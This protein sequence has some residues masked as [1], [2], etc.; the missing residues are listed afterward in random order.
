[1]RQD[2]TMT[3]SARAAIPCA[4]AAA[5]AAML[6]AM[7]TAELCGRQA[8]ALDSPVDHASAVL[9]GR[10]VRIE[11]GVRAMAGRSTALSLAITCSGEGC[12]PPRGPPPPHGMHIQANDEAHGGSHN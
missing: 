8:I 1:M 10:V 2:R 9:L 6:A 11:R 5:L 4:R 12:D 3:T 7:V